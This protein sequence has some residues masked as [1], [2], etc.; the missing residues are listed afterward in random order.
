MLVGK[1][2]THVTPMS[3]EAGEAQKVLHQVMEG[4]GSGVLY[5]PKDFHS[6][7]QIKFVSTPVTPETPN[8]PAIAVQEDDDE[9]E[10]YIHESDEEKDE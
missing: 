1:S 3:H 6:I 7:Q 4:L 9:F 2:K 10:D 8:K 5:I